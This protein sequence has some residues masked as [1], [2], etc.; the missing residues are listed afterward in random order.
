MFSHHLVR[1]TSYASA[2]QNFRAAAS[3]F[4]AK[5]TSEPL[6]RNPDLCDDL[7]IDVAEL[8]A[9][10]PN[11]P[12]LL[13][14]SGLHGVEGF[15]GSCAQIEFMHQVYQGPSLPMHPVILVHG[16]N[17]YGFA[18]LRR[19]N[20]DGI[21]LNRNFL[22]DER[23]YAGCSD[24]Y[25]RLQSFINPKSP[26][27]AVDDFWLAAPFYV[28]RYG[29]AALNQAIA[30]GQYEFPQ[31]L[32]FGGNK[33]SACKRWI[34]NAIIRWAPPGTNLLHIDLHTGLG[35]YREVQF[36]VE[37][38]LPRAQLAQL[39]NRLHPHRVRAHDD[40]VFA[41]P[42]AIGR[43]LSQLLGS[44]YCGLTLEMGTCSPVTLFRLLRRENQAHHACGYDSPSA[45]QARQAVLDAFAPLDPAW[46]QYVIPTVA[47]T[48][49]TLLS[50]TGLLTDAPG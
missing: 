45:S 8:P 10:N 3:Q 9:H 32:F 50:L 20:E 5:L 38:A 35:A 49:H 21:D 48:L 46:W 34:D 19:W 7:T 29:T 30:G 39:H 31:G 28:A 40:V 6:P 4:G 43:Y 25:R 16:L 22:R 33:A 15:A 17:P 11:G 37:S 13:V 42:G 23:A 41:A 18:K 24:A 47:Q 1:P 14:T 36:F 12:R 2:Q 44:R 27:R 26:P